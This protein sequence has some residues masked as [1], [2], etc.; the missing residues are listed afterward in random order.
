MQTSVDSTA[1]L[2]A[3]LTRQNDLLTKILE[4]LNKPELGLLT[5]SPGTVRVYCNRDRCPGALWYTLN[6]A[7][8]PV[9]LPAKAVRGYI[10]QIR[11]EQ[12]ERR[13]KEVW[14]LYTLLN[15]GNA[16][17][18]LES[19]HDSVFTKGLLMAIATMEPEELKQPIS[20]GLAPGDDESVVLCRVWRSDNSPV[21]GKWDE[22]TNWKAVSQQAISNVKA[23]AGV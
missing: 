23:A 8:E 3:A 17:Y 4:S 13:G 22:E 7:R 5:T 15:C 21:F 20:V 12:T 10:R 11:F 16:A 18:E 19:G 6:E 2:L 9:A 1:Q 14:K